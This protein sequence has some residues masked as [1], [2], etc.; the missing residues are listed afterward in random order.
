MIFSVPGDLLGRVAH[1]LEQKGTGQMPTGFSMT[2]EYKLS[3]S[4]A[5]M[6]RQMGMKRSDGSEINGYSAKDR[7][8]SLQYR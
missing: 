6:A 4:Y 1:G 8:M 2:S 7:K 3:E 5:E